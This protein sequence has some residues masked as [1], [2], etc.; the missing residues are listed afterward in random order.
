[1]IIVLINQLWRVFC[2]YTMNIAFLLINTLKSHDNF[3]MIIL[4]HSLSRWYSDTPV[5]LYTQSRIFNQFSAVYSVETGRTCSVITDD[6]ALQTI[7]TY[8]KQEK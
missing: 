4:L 5:I 2:P 1:M 6:T 8:L 7:K 3:S